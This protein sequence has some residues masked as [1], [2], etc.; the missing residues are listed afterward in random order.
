MTGPLTGPLARD[1]LATV[2][3][4]LA[5]VGVLG[6]AAAT[7]TAYAQRG[8]DG[9]PAVESADPGSPSAEAGKHVFDAGQFVG[10]R[11]DNATFEVPSKVDGWTVQ[12]RDTVIYYVDHEG[13]P[14]V[15]VEGAAVF[16][17][18]YCR[19]RPAGSNR[20][21]AG[22]T[23]SATG[24]RTREANTGLSRDWVAAVALNEDLTT[25]S[26]HTPLRTKKVTLADGTPA[27]RSTS[28][29]TV[30]DR[31][32]CDS[33]AVE[34]AMLSFDTGAGVANLVLVHDADAPGTLSDEL[35][36]RILETAHRVRD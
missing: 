1:R 17:A 10:D 15:G 27:I 34:L 2:L 31:G 5:V 21:F 23:R 3:A 33:A 25:S 7:V 8:G 6:T 32:P 4:V 35:A 11:G 9:S 36:D 20:G 30:T 26:P 16:R 28:R 22:F 13:K 14:S 18:G 19:T 29:I 24:V 12:G